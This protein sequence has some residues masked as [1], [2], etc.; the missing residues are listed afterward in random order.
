MSSNTPPTLEN[1]ETEEQP[2]SDPGLLTSLTI[3][4]RWSYNNRILGFGMDMLAIGTLAF[5]TI[6]GIMFLIVTLSGFIGGWVN[7]YLLTT[8]TLGTYGAY[9]KRNTD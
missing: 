5:T 6:L 2:D 3:A 7:V 4:F 9:K 1:G 8:A